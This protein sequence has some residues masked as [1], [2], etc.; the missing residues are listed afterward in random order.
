MRI[1]MHLLDIVFPVNC[2]VCKKTGTLLCI[3]C[4]NDFPKAERQTE[5]WIYPLFDYRHP[6]MKRAVWLF[7]YAGKKNLVK[8]FGENLAEYIMLELSELEPLENFRNPILIPIP[9]SRKRLKERGYNQAELLCESI[10]AKNKNLT[11]MKKVLVKTKET[12]HQARLKDRDNRL[13]NLIGSFEVVDISL[14]K[15]RN[16]ILVDDVTTT[17]ATLT[18]AKKVLR[19]AGARKVIGFTLA[20]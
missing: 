16:I 13:K 15:N 7:K 12:E 10:L 5:E 17:G 18:E 2:L 1:L 6:P 19:K 11:Y 3:A 14:I 9:L 20:H 4:L 8:T